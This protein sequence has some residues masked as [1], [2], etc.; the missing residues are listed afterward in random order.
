MLHL[1]ILPE[2][3][4]FLDEMVPGR[5]TRGAYLST[6]LLAEKARIRDYQDLSMPHVSGTVP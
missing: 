2:A 1:T 3:E 6:L 4:A 5:N